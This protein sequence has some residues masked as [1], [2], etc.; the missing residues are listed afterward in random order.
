MARKLSAET[1]AKISHALKGKAR[2]PQKGTSPAEYQAARKARLAYERA[3]KTTKPFQKGGARFKAIAA[4]A[5]ARGARSPEA[6]A[7]SVLW[8]KYGKTPGTVA[9]IK[10]ARVRASAHPGRGF[11]AARRSA[12][13][14]LRG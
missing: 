13:R 4:A 10:A 12:L 7:A 1:R 5:K 14:R 9:K 3:A 8:K 11:V 2:G 6:V